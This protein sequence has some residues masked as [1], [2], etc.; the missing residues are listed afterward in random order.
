MP[1][2]QFAC[3]GSLPLEFPAYGT[4]DMRETAFLAKY[5]DGS[6]TSRFEYTGHKIMSG[7]PELEGL[8]AT[9]G[10]EKEVNTLIIELRDSY[11]GLTAELY[12]SVFENYDAITRSVRFINKGEK[13]L[14]INKAASMSV[15]IQG[16]DGMELLH[17]YGWWARE[18]HIERTSLIEG[19]QK[20]DSKRGASGHHHNPFIALLQKTPPKPTVRYTASA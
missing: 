5:S 14:F 13:A 17:L 18:R 3:L 11:T 19:I 16:A 20:I 15:D 9:Y 4:G 1:W 7:K 2:G 12:Y 8:P 6:R 10:N